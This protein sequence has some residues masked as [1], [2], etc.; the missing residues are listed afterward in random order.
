MSGRAACAR[1]Q[2]F[3]D[4]VLVMSCDYAGVHV[5]QVRLVLDGVN[6][7]GLDQRIDGDLVLDTNRDDDAG[8]RKEQYYHLFLPVI[9]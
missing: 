4:P 9:R 7:A 1:R 2:K 3:V 6:F 8:N 5:G